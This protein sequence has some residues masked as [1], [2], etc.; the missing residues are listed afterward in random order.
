MGADELA[1]HLDTATGAVGEENVI[2]IGGEAV[3][4]YDMR[5][6]QYVCVC[7]CIT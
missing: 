7:V 5:Y 6:R 3:A 2:N 4:A 1:Q